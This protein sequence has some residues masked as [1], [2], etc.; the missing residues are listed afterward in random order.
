MSRQQQDIDELFDVKNHFYIGNYQQ[1]INE[2]QKLKKTSTPEVAIDRDIFTYRAYMAQNKFLVVLDEIHGASPARVQPLKLLAEYLSNKQ[3]RE[4]VVQQMEQKLESSVQD[5]DILVLVA[6]T[7][8]MHELNYEAA[9]KVLHTSETLEAL[10][11]T[12]DILIKMH[13]IDLAKKKL[14]EMQD[15]DDDATLTQL[16]QAWVNVAM[17]GDKL[18]DAYYIYQELVDK[19]GPSPILLNNQAVTFIGQGK[20]EEAE[21]ALQEALDKDSNF[22]DTLINFIVLSQHTGKGPEVVNRY[23]S[24][25]KDKNA[26]HPFL[27]DLKQKQE[28]FAH[29][30]QQYGPS[31]SARA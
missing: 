23:L 14:K 6:A 22:P 11:I 29:I 31:T 3:K 8:Y 21:A 17:G 7:I 25:L 5:N 1:C 28:E 9:Y 16:A 24:Q 15:K 4:D 10:A 20:Y 13:R 30:C 12:L 2:A 19:Y 26:D 27:K 18:Q